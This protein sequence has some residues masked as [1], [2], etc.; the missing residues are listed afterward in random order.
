MTW[1]VTID[2]AGAKMGGAARFK[3][4]L[5]RYLERSGRD[6]VRV[7]GAAQ[8]VGPVW[9]LRREMTR[10][11]RGRYVSLNNVSFV[12]SGS[13]R[14]TLLRNALHF[15]TAAEL[16]QLDPT[17]RAASRREAAVVRLAARRS[18]VLVAPS[19]AMA[20]RISRALPDLRD[21]IRT[22]AHPVSAD[23]I[24]E[25]PRASAI[26]CP[27]LFSTYKRMADRLAELLAAMDEL[28]RSVRHIA[29][30]RRARRSARVP[31]KPSEGRAAGAPGLRKSFA[32]F[33][34][35]AAPSTSRPASSHSATRSPRHGSAVGQSSPATRR[36]TVKSA[37]TPCADS[38]PAMQTRCETPSSSHWPRRSPPD[39]AP[40]DPDAYFGWLLGPPR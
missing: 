26:L 32:A 20:E 30:Y 1:P 24:T 9:L 37:V 33:G 36:R 3:A 40:F 18:D 28:R 14:W 19:T 35:A 13:E 22:R 15:L 8:R 7:I 16:S 21:R 6:D 38:P 29:R 31:G 11:R 25:L 12:T 5:D 27:V 17:V 39:P 23:A 4:E 34:R 10:S 2:I